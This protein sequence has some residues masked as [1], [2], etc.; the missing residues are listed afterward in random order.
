MDGK[1]VGAISLQEPLFWK[2]YVDGTVNHRGFGVG[3]VLISLE[4]ITI[5]KSLRL[6]FSTTNNEVEYKALLVRMTMVQKMGGKAMGMFS[7]SRLVVGQV[8]GELEAR[9]LR[10]QEY[11]NQVRHLQSGF[12]S[13]NLSQ[14]PRS[15]N[16]HVDSLA[17]L[18]TS[19]A[20]TLPRVIIVEDLYK[21]TEKGG[22]GVHIHQVRVGPSWMDSTV[23]FLKEDTFPESKS[24]ADKVRR[25]APQFWLSEDQSCINALFLDHI[26]C[27]YILK[28]LSYS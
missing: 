19:S 22:N 28:Q 25:K 23:L 17:T 15:R 18:V 13:F 5:K 2:V 21:P 1:S 24:K 7:N 12:E 3:L 16:T 26:C 4:I 10:M 11:L 20:Q 6:G 8:Q 9:D 27:A 14:I